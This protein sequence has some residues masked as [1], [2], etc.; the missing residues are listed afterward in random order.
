MPPPLPEDI[1]L[2]GY[3][4]EI[5]KKLPTA[6]LSAAKY[7]ENIIPLSMQ[8]YSAHT[9]ISI[10]SATLYT[11][12][13]PLFTGL[14]IISSSPDFASD[15]YLSQLYQIIAKCACIIIDDYT[16]LNND[17][18]IISLWIAAE[19][20]MECGSVWAFFLISRRCRQPVTAT[21][22]TTAPTATTSDYH[23][24]TRDAMM[25]ILKVST[26]LAS[27]AARWAGCAAYVDAW[28]TLVEMLWGML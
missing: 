23:I 10:Q 12:L 8:V 27:F 3:L 28:E 24:S 2:L 18:K 14:D 21:T 4:L 25:P 15:P 22:A 7:I 17:N 13:H 26:L 6:T 16:R 9:D 20:V 5:R 11:S 19:R 1:A